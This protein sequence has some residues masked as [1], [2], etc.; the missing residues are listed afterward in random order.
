MCLQFVNCGKFDTLEHPLQLL[1]RIG[2][3]VNNSLAYLY[4]AVF[5]VL[6]KRFIFSS[7]STDIFWR[8][9]TLW[10]K[11][12]MCFFLISMLLIPNFIFYFVSIFLTYLMKERTLPN[13]FIILFFFFHYLN[14]LQNNEI[15][16]LRGKSLSVRPCCNRKRCDS[17][18]IKKSSKLTQA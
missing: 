6:S 2:L 16:L 5:S 13:Q 9:G 17:N 4:T 12:C 1:L 7:S 11:Y 18:A 15:S 14:I 3:Y 8:L 10:I